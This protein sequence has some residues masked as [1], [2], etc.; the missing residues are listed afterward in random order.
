MGRKEPIAKGARQLLCGL[1]E[2]E[3]A[4]QD[5]GVSVRGLFI[6]QG[7][8]QTNS[9]HRESNTILSTCPMGK[10]ALY[11]KKSRTRYSRE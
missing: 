3:K 11:K 1:G 4:G 5:P 2:R 8:D 7:E 9:G 10:V 6:S